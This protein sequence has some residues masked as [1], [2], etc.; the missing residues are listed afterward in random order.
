VA[1]Y[2]LSTEGARVGLLWRGLSDKYMTMADEQGMPQ[3]L[4]CRVATVPN[5]VAVGE[6]EEYDTDSSMA[7]ADKEKIGNG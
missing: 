1:P 4:M 5:N 2:R 6:T 7:S 3:V